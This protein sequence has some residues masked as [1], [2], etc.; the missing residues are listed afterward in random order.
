[1]FYIRDSPIYLFS[2]SKDFEGFT[3]LGKMAKDSEVEFVESDKHIIKRDLINRN[4]YILKYNFFELAKSDFIAITTICFFTHVFIFF[5]LMGFVPILIKTIDVINKVLRTE[6]DDPQLT[7]R[8]HDLLI[9]YLFSIPSG[10]IAY[11]LSIIKV[12]RK[13]RSICLLQLISALLSFIVMFLGNF[14]LVIFFITAILSMIHCVC[15]QIIIVYIS[16]VFPT[17]LRDYAQ[18]FTLFFSYLISSFIPLMAK[19]VENNVMNIYI[20]FG[21]LSLLSMFCSFFLKVDT[22]DR[23]LDEDI[24]LIEEK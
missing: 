12:F 17:R 20:M 21:V 18:S 24:S 9:F 5:N 6:W 2:K 19:N 13:G 3:I 22:Y 4:N 10:L 7:N 1:L 11:Y 14:P 8:N 15:I 16:E 23:P